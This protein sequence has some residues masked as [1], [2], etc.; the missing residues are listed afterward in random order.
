VELTDAEV[1]GRVLR[2][3]TD[4]YSVLVDR[5]YDR[6]ARYALHMLGNR[7]DAEEAVQDAFVRAY[8]SLG[9]YEDRDRFGAFLFRILINRCRTAGAKQQRRERRFSDR[10]SA[11]LEASEEHPAERAAWREEIYF[12]LDT[13]PQDQREAFLLKHVEE[14]SYDEMAVV[15]GA[16]VSALKMRVKRACDRLRELLKEAQDV[17]EPRDGRA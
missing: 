14:L 2:G 1:L 6:C 12:A 5:Y 11:L 9:R 7:E 10:E 8:R 15:T 17:R 16:T 13:L 4:A 3:D